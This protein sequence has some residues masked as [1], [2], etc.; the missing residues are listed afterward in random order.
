MFKGGTMG[1]HR[2]SRVWMS[3]YCSPIPRPRQ[4]GNRVAGW[5]LGRSCFVPG[6]L[7]LC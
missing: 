5:E 4:G 1:T 2:I 3:A 6:S 7:L